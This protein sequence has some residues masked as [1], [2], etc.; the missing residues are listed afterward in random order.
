MPKMIMVPE[1]LLKKFSEAAQTFQEL[2]DELEDFLLT[3][4]PEF[5]S[6][7]RQARTSHL[8]GV[9][10]PLAEFKKDLCID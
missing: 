5:L 8:K 1:T 3:S 4:D 6:A 10:R 2:E 7:M 9:T